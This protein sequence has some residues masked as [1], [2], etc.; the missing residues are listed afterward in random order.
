MISFTCCVV[1]FAICIVRLL[2]SNIHVLV[3]VLLYNC[4]FTMHTCSF[5]YASIYINLKVQVEALSLV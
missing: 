2:S 1:L 3:L 4:C 5:I